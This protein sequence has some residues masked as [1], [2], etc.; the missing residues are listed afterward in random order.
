MKLVR[1]IL[2]LL[3]VWKYRHLKKITCCFLLGLGLSLDNRCLQ[4]F[5]HLYKTHN[6]ILLEI[7]AIYVVVNFH[8]LL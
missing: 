5:L 8:V 3:T 2:L 4:L 6:S 7:A 1:L